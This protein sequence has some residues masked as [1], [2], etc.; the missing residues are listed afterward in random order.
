MRIWQGRSSCGECDQDWCL[1]L[2]LLLEVRFI[3]FKD[4]FHVGLRV[5]VPFFIDYSYSASCHRA[6]LVHMFIATFET[7]DSIFQY[8]RN[9]ER[10]EIIPFLG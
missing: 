9:F 4:R 8:G 2:S 3:D 5:F 1:L 7:L 10:D 6:K